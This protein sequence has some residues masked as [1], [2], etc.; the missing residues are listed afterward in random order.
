MNGIRS[1]THNSEDV[2]DKTLAKQW[3]KFPWKKARAFVK[4]LQTRIAKAVKN[5][6]YRLAKR[7]QYLLTHSYY[8]KVLAIHRVAG[9][10]GRKSAGVDGEKWTTPQDKMRAALKLSDKGYRAKPLRR[11]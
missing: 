4:R 10:K 2:S 3:R 11:I 5:G 1:I 7:L 9:N 8:A 6:N